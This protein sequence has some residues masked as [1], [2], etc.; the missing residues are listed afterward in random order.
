MYDWLGQVVAAV[1]TWFA[2]ETARAM[3]AG[4]AGGLLRWLG[5]EG[6]RLWD[7]ALAVISGSLA[8]LYMAPL[9]TSILAAVGLDLGTGEAADRAAGFVAGLAGMSIAKV[10]IAGIEAWAAKQT[11]GGNDGRS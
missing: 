5:Q 7:G 11:T 6:R 1:T 8:A 2:G 9:V 4:A 3:I 10:V